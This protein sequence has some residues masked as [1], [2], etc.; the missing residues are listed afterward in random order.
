MGDPRL[1]ERRQAGRAPSRTR[2][3]EDSSSRDM[4][5]T[6]IAARTA[7][8]SP[9]R[10]SGSACAW[11]SSASSIT[12]AIPTPRP[13]P[14]PSWSTRS[15]T[16][17]TTEMEEDWEG[18]LSVP[19]LRGRV[20][21]FT[22]LRYTG[23]DPEG[24]PIRARGRR[25]PRPRRAAR[26]RPPGR[27]PV[28]RCACATCDSFGYATSCSPT[29]EVIR[30]AHEGLGRSADAFK[31]AC[32]IAPVAREVSSVNRS[33]AGFVVQRARRRARK[34]SSARS[35]SVLIFA[36]ATLMFAL[37][38]RVRDPRRAAPAGRR[39]RSRGCS[40]CPCRQG[41]CGPPASAR[42]CFRLPAHAS[43]RRRL[44]RAACSVSIRAELELDVAD[45]L[46]VGGV[47]GFA[48][49]CTVNVSS[50]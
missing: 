41:K 3:A 10:R 45:H 42:K 34:T 4:R 38:Q 2:G 28:S 9:R 32:C 23:F 24:A 8:S 40:A 1:L 27:H 21:R 36:L 17:L 29:P 7:R 13:Y 26:V 6:M 33:S 16:P 44:R 15:S 22:R 35:P 5:E 19:G 50:A 46:A 12:S 31:H 37:R 43:D 11:S 20:P 25:V 18:C 39:R 47:R 14:I 30:G 48:G 49:S